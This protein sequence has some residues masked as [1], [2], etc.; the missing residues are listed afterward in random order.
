MRRK[1][2]WFRNLF[3][4]HD[5]ELVKKADIYNYSLD[6]KVPIGTRWVYICKI[7]KECKVVKDYQ[8]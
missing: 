1:I 2:D 3:H 8:E 6:K 4:K 5:W 7:C